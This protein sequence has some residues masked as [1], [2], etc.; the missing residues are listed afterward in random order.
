[1][2][3]LLI[4]LC[5]L[6]FEIIHVLFVFSGIHEALRLVSPIIHAIFFFIGTYEGRFSFMASIC[7]DFSQVVF[8]SCVHE[9][10]AVIH[11]LFGFFMD[12]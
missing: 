12:C 8:F 7:F 2:L 3:G 11:L 5:I 6:F 1:L 10:Y 9:R 4:G